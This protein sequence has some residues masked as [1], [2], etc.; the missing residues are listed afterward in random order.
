MLGKLS[1]K[2]VTEIIIIVLLAYH[3]RE[4]DRLDA[5]CNGCGGQNRWHESWPKFLESSEDEHMAL[6][7]FSQ[8]IM[9]QLDGGECS[10]Y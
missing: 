9:A 1:A 6:S 4:A 10:A 7:V 5:I 3:L 8:Y 2:E